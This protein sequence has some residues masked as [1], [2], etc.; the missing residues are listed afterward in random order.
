MSGEGRRVIN[1]PRLNELTSQELDSL[2]PVTVND[3]VVVW[4]SYSSI[5]PA[6]VSLTVKQHL[7]CCW[8]TDSILP[9]LRSLIAGR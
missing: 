5:F 6:A 8:G 3:G 9:S 2:L 7:V 1:S 4:P